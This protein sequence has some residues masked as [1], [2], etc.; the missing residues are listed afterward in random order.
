MELGFLILLIL[1]LCL[2]MLIFH[3]SS[4]E[5]EN[6]SKETFQKLSEKL[7][8]DDFTRESVA[9]LETNAKKSIQEEFGFIS[10]KKKCSHHPP[11]KIVYGTKRGVSDEFVNWLT[12]SGDF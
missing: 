10:R 12:E 11:T 8:S 7:S 4:V 5:L 6:S 2:F 9:V 3:S 1:L